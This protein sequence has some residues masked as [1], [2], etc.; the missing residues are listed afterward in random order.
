MPIL[1]CARMVAAGAVLAAAATLVVAQ[2]A[3]SRYQ[4]GCCEGARPGLLQRCKARWEFYWKPYHQEAWWGYP[5]EFEEAPFGSSV[6]ANT[7]VQL[8][9]AEAARMTL[10]Q[11]DFVDGTELLKP[12]GKEQVAK[13]ALL[14]CKNF[15]PIVIEQGPQV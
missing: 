8:D 4:S 14:A 2:D 9:N 7:R 3:N 13:I 11:Y 15:F 5:E 6:E 1:R 10:Y 12:R